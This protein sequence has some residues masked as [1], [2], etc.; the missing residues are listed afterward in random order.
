MN[1]SIRLF[2]GFF[3]IVGLA[4]WFVLNIISQEIEPGIRQATEETLVDTANMLAELAAPEL[5]AN[6]INDGT[7]SKAIQAA[8]Q[9]APEAFISGVSKH[10]VDFQIYVTDAHGIVRFDSDGSGLGADYSRWRDVARVLRGEYGARSTRQD[11]NDPHSS[12]MYIAAPI[13]HKGELVGV[14]SVAKPVATVLPYVNRAQERVRNTGLLL[15]AAASLIG[16]VFTLWLAWS[17]GRLR[18]YARAIGEGRKATPPTSGGSQF[19]ELARTL[20]QMRE[21]LDG[22][23]YVETYVQ[24]L[25]HEM[26]SPLT[27]IVG[28]AELLQGTLPDADRQHFSSSITEQAQRLRQIVDRMLMLARIEH[29]QEPG[30]R[31]PV[32]LA[33]LAR[34][35][36]AER[37]LVLRSNQLE[38][39]LTADENL[40]VHGDR[41]L[42]Q[43][44]LLNLIDNAIDF[45][46]PRGRI[47]LDIHRDGPWLTMSVRDQ[48]EGVPDYALPQ[49]FERFYSLPRPLTGRK[50]TGLGLPLVREI[51][52]LHSGEVHFINHPEG[53][54]C[55]SLML[56]AGA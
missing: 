49:L 11:P 9:R 43:Q 51:A 36:L 39:T 44:A 4:A 19:A 18:Q 1:I 46:P 52:R 50:S 30:E 5:V 55:A 8:R 25:A 47:T 45:S 53:G 16:V 27:A 54:G 26:K 17:I 22:K 12:V 33:E 41:L 56:P 48:G 14:L 21:R 7:F 15:V 23:Q 32:N 6:R 13:L 20:A 10:S 42:L 24:N 38:T 40:I 3:L 34:H 29:L 31:H 35:S 37:Q 2:A 28:A